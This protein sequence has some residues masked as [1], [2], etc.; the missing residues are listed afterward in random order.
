[1]TERAGQQPALPMSSSSSPKQGYKATRSIETP[2]TPE[3]LQQGCA[4]G[5]PSLS[6][7]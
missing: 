4:T 6:V 3:V 2:F 7:K 1:M 5:T